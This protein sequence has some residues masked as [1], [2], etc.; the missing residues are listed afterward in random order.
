[1]TAE[2]HMNLNYITFFSPPLENQV[3]VLTTITIRCI[4]KGSPSDFV[5]LLSIQS[6]NKYQ[7]LGMV[8]GSGDLRVNMIDTMLT[9]RSSY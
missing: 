5:F 6:F 8:L 4:S 2:G 7:V 1:M 9:L 3:V